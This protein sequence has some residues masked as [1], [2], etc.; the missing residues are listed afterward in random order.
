M[1][2]PSARKDGVRHLVGHG[3]VSQRRGCQIVEV[4]R[5]CVRYEGR[6]RPEEAAL[7][8]EIRTLATRHKRFGY[9]RIAAVLRRKGMA[10][11]TK[12]VHRIWKAEGLSLPARRPRKRRSGPKGEVVRKAEKPNHVWTYDFLED[13]TERGG[14]LKMLTILDEY[15]RESL[16][17][18]VGRSIDSQKVIETLR[19]LVIERGAPDHIRSDNGPEFI[20]RAVQEWIRASGSRTIFI[21]PGS[22]WENPYIE[23]FN[24]K[25][26]DECLNMEVFASGKEAQMIVEA[27]RTDYNEGRPHSSLGYQTPA[28]FA[29]RSGS[30]GREPSLRFQ[31]DS[32]RALTLTL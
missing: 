24:G 30:F 19:G 11:N 28:E 31:N 5:S 2:T 9:R 6:L 15:T 26:R 4:S 13:R 22:P 20:A 23:S 17:I 25:F 14:R 16:A 29:V 8:Q 32:T 3:T 18:R 27:W 1:V 21:S 10:V 7:R 12:R